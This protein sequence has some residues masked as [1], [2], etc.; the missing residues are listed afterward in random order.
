MGAKVEVEGNKITGD[1]TMGGLTIAH[2]AACS[3]SPVSTRPRVNAATKAAGVPGTGNG[4]V[5]ALHRYVSLE[6]GDNVDLLSGTWTVPNNPKETGGLI[7]LFNAIEPANGSWILQ[8]VLQFGA[9][10]FFGGNYWVIASW[11]VGSNGYA[12]YSPAQKVSS[13]DTI[14]G[15]TYIT[16]ESSGKLYYEVWAQDKTSGA[17]SWIRATSTGL[18]WNE[19]YAGVLEAYGISSCEQLPAS[20]ATIFES[21]Q[22]DHGYPNFD[23]ELADFTGWKNSAW[24]GPSCAIDPVPD[25]SKQILYYNYEL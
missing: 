21:T 24:A 12:F 15:S 1:I 14:Y 4:W 8:P 13:G 5:E 20:S 16:S 7:Y 6:S 23:S 19:A 2:Y 25:G 17:Y 22:V 11:M 9:N 10:S 18:Q 3:E